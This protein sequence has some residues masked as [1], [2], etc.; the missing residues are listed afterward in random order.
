MTN[1][2]AQ[3]PGNNQ[4]PWEN[5]ESFLRT[6][7]PANELFIVSGPAGSGGTGSNGGVTTTLANGHVTVPA[8]TWKC[9]LILPS[10]SGDPVARVTASTQAVCVIMPNLDSIRNDD[11]HTYVTSVDQV[12][13]LTG[14][15]L[16]SNIP[17]AIENAVEGGTYPGTNPPGAANQSV[18]TNED[19]A[20]AFTLD[21]ANATANPLTYTIVSPPSHGGLTGSNGS[22]T[23]T[24]APDFNGTDTFTYNVNDGSKTS[25][26]ATVTITVLEVNDPPAAVDDSKSTTAN[27]V[28]TFPSS[29][30]TGNDSTGPANENGQTLTVTTVT[31]TANTHG[32]ATLA[33]GTVTYTP[34]SGY[35]G[36][37]SF[38]YTVCDNG[39]TVGLADPLC[40]TAT[41]NVTVATQ[42]AT[43]F[44]IIAPPI[45]T[46]GVAFNVAVTALDASN[47]TVTGYT[48]TV[49]FT[50]SSAGTLP[51]DYTFTGGDSGVHSFNVTLTTNGAQ[52]ITATDTVTASI[53]GSANTMVS[54]PP[55]PPAT[56]FSVTAPGSVT[57]GVAFNVAVTALDASN[58]TVP[59]YTGTVHF[60]S[61]SAGTLP[62]DYTF[63]AGDSGTHSF[64][65]T[66]TTNG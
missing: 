33:S 49:H 10:G 1:M 61:S 39:V 66:L 41:V 62:G 52:S 30:L 14:Y 37:A 51:G 55:P 50:S 32:T 64:N 58:A 60:S 35:T 26:T 65:V 8:S 38:T 4:G 28:L 63:T 25:N 54:S 18:S 24:P 13:T 56:H 46:N 29:D 20:K 6:L 34:D 23:Y 3:A 27:A 16:F 47:A 45:V 7:L 48:G 21:T 11:W 19:T 15:D 17:D 42:Q 22:R 43:H 2:L 36:P 59:G 40:S 5:L 53:T 9:A 44:G 12:E 31:Q 57:N